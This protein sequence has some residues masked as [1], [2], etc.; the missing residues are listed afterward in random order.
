MRGAEPPCPLVSEGGQRSLLK[1]RASAG[2][3]EGNLRGHLGLICE[4]KFLEGEHVVG[5]GKVG[6]GCGIDDVVVVEEN[7][8]LRPKKRFRT[9]WG[10]EM[11]S[12]FANTRRRKDRRGLVSETHG[13]R[14]WRGTPC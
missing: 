4:A 7:C 1:P 3:Q 8:R 11:V 12:S 2:V 9:S 13:S 14:R 5:R 10:F 6:Q